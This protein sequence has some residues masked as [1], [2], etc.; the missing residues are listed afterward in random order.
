M[1]MELEQAKLTAAQW[2]LGQTSARYESGA[3]G[4]GAISNGKGDHGGASYGSY[5]FSSSTGTLQEYLAQSPYGEQ[6]LALTPVTPKFD[7]KWRDLALSDPGER[8]QVHFLT[9]ERGR[10]P[11]PEAAAR[12]SGPRPLVQCSVDGQTTS[13]RPARHPSACRPARQQPPA[14]LPG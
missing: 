11:Q 6:F 12:T 2:T 13:T 9:G 10:L 3:A 1:I 5:Q 8:G 4:A 14:L 7:T